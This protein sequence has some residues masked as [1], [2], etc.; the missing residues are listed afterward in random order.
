LRRLFAD[1]RG[2]LCRDVQERPAKNPRKSSF[3]LCEICVEKS[4]SSVRYASQ[5]ALWQTGDLLGRKF[6]IRAY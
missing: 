4:L 6:H 1:E 3:S 2:W 5:R